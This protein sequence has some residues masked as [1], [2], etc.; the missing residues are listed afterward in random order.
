MEIQLL[1]VLNAIT[2][3]IQL[4]IADSMDFLTVG[5]YQMVG[6]RGLYIL[7]DVLQNIRYKDVKE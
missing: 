3:G 5:E 7:S 4:D 2:K 6:G 1:L